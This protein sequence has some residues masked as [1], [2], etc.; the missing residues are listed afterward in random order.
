MT[1]VAFY[2]KAG[3]QTG[4]GHIVRCL[5]LA[6]ELRERGCECV[7]YGNRLAVERA[8]AKGYKAHFDK[9][10]VKII[11]KHLDGLAEAMAEEARKGKNA[12]VFW[13]DTELEVIG[14]EPQ[15]Y[16]VWIIDLEGGCPPALAAQ[17]RDRCKVLVIL[18]GVGYPDGDPGR[19]LAD[20]V[21]YQGVTRRPYELDWSGFEGEWFEGPKWLILR[22][23]FQ[24]T[25]AKPGMHDR[26]RVVV[27]CGGSDPKDV[28][29]K[30][31]NALLKSGMSLRVI[32]GPANC[33]IMMAD[34][35]QAM[36][37]DV[38]VIFDPSN[39]AESLAW[40]DV[41]IVS[42][43]MTAFECLALGLPTIALSI[44]PDHAASA[45]LVQSQSNGALMH[46]GEVENV[47]TEGI[48]QAVQ[49]MLLTPLHYSAAAR[50]FIDGEGTQRVADEIMKVIG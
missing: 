50:R 10:V 37:R 34:I 19:L 9:P 31:V 5:A 12:P 27:A 17:L 33:G 47:T 43:G 46:L 49:K 18:N 4:Y 20:L 1:Q 16:D 25:K 32:R 39:M 28:T 6:D 38:K 48:R 36:G 45:D 15:E 40:A 21:F 26:P 30:V 44:S 23:D 22:K 2:V 42:Y 8:D 7:F 35:A 13:G 24:S 14:F 11:D 29:G 41:A 3:K